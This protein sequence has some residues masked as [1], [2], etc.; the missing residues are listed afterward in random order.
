M[1]D[2]LMSRDFLSLNIVVN[3]DCLNQIEIFD[4]G[5]LGS[6]DDEFKDD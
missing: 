5:S 4:E 6:N 3:M 1:V 2:V